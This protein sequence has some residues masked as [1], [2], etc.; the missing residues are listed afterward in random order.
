MFVWSIEH[1]KFSYVRYKARIP[2]SE[3]KG[4]FLCLNLFEIEFEKVQ[5]FKERRF[6]QGHQKLIVFDDP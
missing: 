2:S 4:S 1:W 5:G 3:S 6:M